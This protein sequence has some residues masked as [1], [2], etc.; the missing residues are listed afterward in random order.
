[1]SGPETIVAAA[2]LLLAHGGSPNASSAET[3]CGRFGAI[4]FGTTEPWAL[5]ECK[6]AIRRTVNQQYIEITL[7]WALSECK[8]AIRRTVNQQYIEITVPPQKL[9]LAISSSR[10]SARIDH[11]SYIGRTGHPRL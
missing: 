5:S 9:S 3:P 4:E 1:M 7:P 6:C 8:C 10:S 11:E 2:N